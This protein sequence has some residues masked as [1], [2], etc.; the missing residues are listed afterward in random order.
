MPTSRRRVEALRVQIKMEMNP[1]CPRLSNHPYDDPLHDPAGKMLREAF[2]KHAEKNY[3]EIKQRLR[4][5]L[6]RLGYV[7]LPVKH[8]RYSIGCL[9]DSILMHMPAKKRGILGPLA[10]KWVRIIHFDSGGLTMGCLAGEVYVP[11]D[12]ERALVPRDNHFSKN[13]GSPE[14]LAYLAT[15]QQEVYIGRVKHVLINGRMVSTRLSKKDFVAG[16]AGEF[17]E[18]DH[19]IANEAWIS[20]GEDG[21]WTVTPRDEHG[22]RFIHEGELHEFEWLPVGT[23][24]ECHE[25]DKFPRYLLGNEFRMER[26]ADGWKRLDK[27]EE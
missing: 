24:V 12:V 15:C 5:N 18:A 1:I 8:A 13:N 27:W 20:R 16:R 7:F 14:L 22:K 23:L 4:L 19:V 25:K 2:S 17:P 21:K 6:W 11:A 9:G 26:T 3:R 10:G